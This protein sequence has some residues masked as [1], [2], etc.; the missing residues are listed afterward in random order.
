MPPRLSALLFALAFAPPA[1]RAQSPPP[2][3]AGRA[4]AQGAVGLGLM[5]VGFIGG[6]LATRWV[7]NRFGATGDPASTIALVG[8]YT[9]AGLTTAAGPTIV[10]GGSHASGSYGAALAGAAV[11]G[12]GSILLIRLNKTVNTGPVLRILSAVGVVLLPSVGATVGYDWSRTY[13]R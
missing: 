10:G 1:L 9:I 5:P 3:T 13:R 4:I 8:A 7:A 12:A 11:G 6:G 2:V